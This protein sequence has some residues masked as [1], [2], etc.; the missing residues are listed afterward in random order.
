MESTV[1]APAQPSSVHAEATSLDLG[2]LTGAIAD[3][4]VL[5]ESLSPTRLVRRGL[6]AEKENCEVARNDAASQSR[7]TL[8]GSAE[9]SNLERRI[10]ACA[11]QEHR[12]EE[13]L[14]TQ[15]LPQHGPTQF[16]GPRA[17]LQTPL[18]RVAGK[19]RARQGSTSLV[20]VAQPQVA[21]RGPELRQSDG[22]VFASLLHMAR[23]VRV[24][25]GV[26][27]HAEDVCRTLFGR[28]DGNTRRQLREHIQRLQ[29]GVIAFDTFSIQLCLRFD[30]PNRG[31]WSVNLDPNIVALFRGQT[32]V[33]LNVA[34][35]IQLPEGLATWLYGYVRSQSRLIPMQL[36]ILRQQ[37]GS[38]ASPKAFMN[39][40][41]LALQEL[42]HREVIAPGWSLGA[43]RVRWMKGPN[44]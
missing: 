6:L 15:L 33:W 13:V 39:G 42:A 18:F 40:M 31:R 11:E 35:R 24:D 8:R 43:G 4:R 23:D 25:T 26:S 22:L 44:G 34:T 37:C 41:R 20:L 7:K 28:Y 16:I 2:L 1:N 5:S 30:Y 19:Q 21:Y 32:H 36:D 17:F 9:K 14:Q 29:S 12:I 38:E 3:V 10:R 27:F